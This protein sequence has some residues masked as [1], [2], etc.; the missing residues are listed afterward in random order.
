MVRTQVQ[1]TEEQAR[2]LKEMAGTGRE[3][4]AALIRRA[5]DQFLVNRKPDRMTL[6]RQAEAVVGKYEAGNG[7]ISLEHDQYLE[8]AYAQ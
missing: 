7:N 8:E 5:L 1:L 4:M 6:Y 3:S 2:L